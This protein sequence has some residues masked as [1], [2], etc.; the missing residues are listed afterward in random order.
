MPATFAND[1]EPQKEIKPPDLHF[2]CDGHWK[3]IGPLEVGEDKKGN[4]TMGRTWVSL[5]ETWSARSPQ[6]FM[7]RRR[8]TKPDGPDP[9]VVYIQRSP[10]HG[11]NVY[12]VGLTRRNPDVRAAELSSATGV[13]MPFDV[14]GNWE[15]GDCASVEREVHTRLANFRINPRREFFYAELSF[16]NR[17]IDAVVREVS[18]RE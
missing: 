6:S 10:S 18:S 7:L 8:E 15:V 9:G 12:K 2:N 11:I 3:A 4:P 14:L 17:T 1:E 16:I 5:H 13:P